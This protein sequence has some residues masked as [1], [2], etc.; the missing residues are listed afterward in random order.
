MDTR[1][2]ELIRVLQEASHGNW[3]PALIVGGLFSLLF[4]LS[5]YIIKLILKANEEKHSETFNLLA[6]LTESQQK[7]DIVVAQLQTIVEYH[8]KHL[9]K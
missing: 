2:Q 3:Y 5:G 1:E 6:K 9:P 4:I 7:T 8:E